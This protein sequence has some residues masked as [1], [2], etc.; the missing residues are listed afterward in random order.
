[1]EGEKRREEEKVEG[2]V[3]AYLDRCSDWLAERPNHEHPDLEHGHNLDW[4][5]SPLEGEGGP[6]GEPTFSLA[7]AWPAGMLAT[8]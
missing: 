1:M 2:W 8:L 5:T 7:S 6:R 4:W 3:A